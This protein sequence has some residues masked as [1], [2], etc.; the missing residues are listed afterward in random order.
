M[1]ES[2]YGMP[3]LKTRREFEHNIF[4]LAEDTNRKMDSGNNNVIR[5][6]FWATYPHIKNIRDYPNG[7]TNFLTVNGQALLQANMKKW[8]GDFARN[9]R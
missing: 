1:E 3:P 5:N 6:F 7:R 8:M 9:R 2:K 4:L